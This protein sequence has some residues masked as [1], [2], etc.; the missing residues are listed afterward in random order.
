M[1]GV[2]RRTS[3][4]AAV[5]DDPDKLTRMVKILRFADMHEPPRR[6]RRSWRHVGI[7]ADGSPLHLLTKPDT[8][9]PHAVLYLHG[10]GYMFGPSLLE[11]LTAA[12]IAGASSCDLGVFLYPKAPEHRA[13]ETIAATVAAWDELA[14][15]YAPD[16]VTLVGVSSG[17]GLAVALMTQLRDRG[18]PQ[19]ANAILLSPGVDLTLEDEASHLERGD[20][21]LSPEFVR[22]AGSLYA[23]DL[24]PNDPSVSP[25]FGDL[26]GLA[27]MHV[28]AGTKEILFPGLERFVAKVVESGGS[29][30]LIV[31]ERQ[32]HT[33]P[34]APTAEGKRA[35]QHIVDIITG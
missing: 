10:G 19:P 12:S 33:W 28:F 30:N 23:G 5:A 11:W 34:T 1:L 27:P 9:A 22:A 14:G 18:S 21:L 24:P 2:K 26:A 7:A 32:Q 35:I 29:A 13:P 17:G 20:L 31:G 25:S 3:R 6:L 8:T 15:R 16:A 4:L